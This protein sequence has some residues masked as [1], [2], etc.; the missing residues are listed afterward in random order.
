MFTSQSYSVRNNNMR[1]NNI[2]KWNKLSSE[3][4]ILIKIWESL[5]RLQKTH[6]ESTNKNW[7]DKHWTTSAKLRTTSSIERTAGS[8]RPW[9]SQTADTIA[10]FATSQDTDEVVNFSVL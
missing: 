6:Q 9:S 2:I 3:D 1:N 10:S 5:R 8:Q 4:K 7:K